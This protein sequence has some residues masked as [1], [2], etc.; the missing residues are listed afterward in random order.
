MRNAKSFSDRVQ[1]FLFQNALSIPLQPLTLPHMTRPYFF[2]LA[3]IKLFS[4][5]VQYWT[6]ECGCIPCSFLTPMWQMSEFSK[7]DKMVQNQS[8]ECHDTLLQ[9]CYKSK[10]P[11]D[12][13]LKVCIFSKILYIFLQGH[14]WKYSRSFHEYLQ[15]FLYVFSWKPTAF[16][17][18]PQEVFV[19]IPFRYVCKNHFKPL[20]RNTLLGLSKNPS[21]YPMKIYGFSEYPLEEFLWKYLCIYG[22]ENIVLDFFVLVGV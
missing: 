20:C 10:N 17:K 15:K 21:M 12:V 1:N 22:L 9:P 14:S 11:L 8:S 4:E 6:L 5:G 19:K 18:N 3:G 2:N 16:H 13:F 7:F